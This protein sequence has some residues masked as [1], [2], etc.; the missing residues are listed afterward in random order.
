MLKELSKKFRVFCLD[1]IGMGLS[2]KDK[3]ECK[4]TE[5]TLDLFIGSIEK[6]RASVGL[7]TFYLV[8][9]SLGGYIGAQYTLRHKERVKKLTLL[10][11]AGITKYRDE[12]S[13][14]EAKKRFGFFKKLFY[15][16]F[17]DAWEKKMTPGKFLKEYP[18]IGKLVLQQ[19]ISTRLNMKGEEAELLKEYLIIVLTEPNGTQEAVHYLLKSPIAGAY[20][21]LEYY[22]V[23]ELDQ[24][25]DC[26]YGEFDYMDSLGARRIHENKKKKN[27]SFKILPKAAHQLPMENPK[28]LAEQI[29]LGTEA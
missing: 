26:F 12:P 5:E 15:G 2:T 10:S 22:I 19:Y 29:V 14:E 28:I 9:H 8:G 21:P 4:S 3:F 13:L 18:W 27:F 23:E 25:V 6:W 24:P 20:I 1:F 17:M 7:Q 16:V 11:P